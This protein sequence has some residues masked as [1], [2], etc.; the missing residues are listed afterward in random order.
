[1]RM[2]NGKMVY[3]NGEPLTA[4]MDNVLASRLGKVF[5]ALQENGSNGIGDSIDAGLI[6]CHLLDQAG[7][8]VIE[9]Q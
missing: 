9:K 1:M 3:S 7:F 8:N 6:L 2:T 4:L 5:Y